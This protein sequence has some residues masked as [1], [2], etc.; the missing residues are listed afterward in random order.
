MGFMNI[1]RNL[2]LFSA[3]SV[4]GVS[5]GIHAEILQEHSENNNGKRVLKKKRWEYHLTKKIFHLNL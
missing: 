3:V 5:I 4:I 1:T 2:V